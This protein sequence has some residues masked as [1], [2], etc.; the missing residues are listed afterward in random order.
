MARLARRPDLLLLLL[1]AALVTAGLVALYSTTHGPAAEF[2]PP[3][4][5]DNFVRQLFWAGLSLVAMGTVLL[6]PVRFFQS[7]A[8]VIYGTT[9]ALLL[10]TL[11]VGR[12]I[13]GAKAWLYIG[14]I[15]FQT[16]ELAKVGTVLA[17]A[18]LL[19]TRQARI[20][21]VRYALGAVALILV[22]AAIIILQND[23]GTALVFL[24]L[25]P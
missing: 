6:L 24:A 14:S 23:M 25:V 17:V 22:P 13:N 2:L 16:S 21:T 7:M 8:Y 15:G 9:V 10:L 3:S 4:V 20:D 12:E 19:S 1:W 5:R 18:R 11:A